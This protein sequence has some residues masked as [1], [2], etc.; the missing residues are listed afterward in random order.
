MAK[1]RRR[2][3][4]SSNCKAT[5][6]R[7]HL[8]PLLESLSHADIRFTNATTGALVGGSLG[9][10]AAYGAAAPFFQYIFVTFGQVDHAGHKQVQHSL[11]H[12]PC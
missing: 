9:A 12:A 1:H 4:K 5:V 7:D 6:P 8:P 3:L 10:L 2:R 11:A